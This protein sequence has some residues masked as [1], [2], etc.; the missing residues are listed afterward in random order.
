MLITSEDV[1]RNVIFKN[2]LIPFTCGQFSES[3]T[4]HLHRQNVTFLQPLFYFQYIS[5]LS[6]SLQEDISL[7]FGI[8]W[9]SYDHRQI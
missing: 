9:L 1:V 5:S 7:L 2:A 3:T 4:L 6:Q 8:S